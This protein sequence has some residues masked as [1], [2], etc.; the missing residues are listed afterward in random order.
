MLT[1][2][3]S[4]YCCETGLWHALAGSDGKFLRQL[5]ARRD[6]DMNV[7]LLLSLLLLLQPRVGGLWPPKKYL[8]GCMLSRRLCGDFP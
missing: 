8:C 3:Y 7:K 4:R 5:G 6:L 1:I 2:Y